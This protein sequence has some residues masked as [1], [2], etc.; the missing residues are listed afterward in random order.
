M[1]EP[2]LNVGIL[3]ATK[4]E[5]ELQNEFV[6]NCEIVSGLHVVKLEDNQIKWNNQLFH[7]LL[8]M[9]KNE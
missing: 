6:F 5:F 3:F 4:I 8:L 7:E 1:N 2:K 9:P